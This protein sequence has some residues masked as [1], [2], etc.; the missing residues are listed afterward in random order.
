MVVSKIYNSLFVKKVN[1]IINLFKWNN[2]YE[3]NFPLLPT[4]CIVTPENIVDRYKGFQNEAYMHHS[5]IARNY[6]KIYVAYSIH[7]YDEDAGGQVV[8]ISYSE[9]NGNSWQRMS[10]AMPKMSNTVEYGVNP[11][12]WSY[13]SQF[14]KIKSGFYIFINSV[15]G[16]INIEYYQP[17]GSLIREIKSDNTYGE[18]MWVNNGVSETD[19]TI[20][21]PIIGY[22]SYPFASDDLILEV[23]SYL[24]NDMLKPKILFGWNEIW[25]V[26]E[27]FINNGFP[28]REPT[29][30][31]PYNYKEVLKVWK[32]GNINYNIVQNGEDNSTQTI[33]EIPNGAGFPA[34]RFYNYSPE[35]II[36]VG[37]SRKPNREELMLFLARKNNITGQFV[38]SNGDVYSVS[39]I[40][41]SNPVYLGKNKSG[42]EQLPFINRVNKN[43][44]DIAYSV[45]KEEIYFQTIDVSKLI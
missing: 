2:S 13:P 27:D 3:Q 40:T 8:G 4:N 42:G 6:N 31:K 33:S 43:L 41:K 29:E 23:K 19:R 38:V 45:S 26:Q 22:P 34:K 39:S 18:I 24:S 9:D 16:I 30:I 11:S 10:L 44:L 17:L 32:I 15:Y 21:T 12:Q 7:D 1:N 37:H 14:I 25:S 28:L 20:P 36:S 5:L 35:I